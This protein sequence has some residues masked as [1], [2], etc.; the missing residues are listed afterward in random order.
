M[1]INDFP[2]PKAARLAKPLPS[3]SGGGK[4]RS[5]GGWCLLTVVPVVLVLLVLAVPL[6]ALRAVPPWFRSAASR[7]P[8]RSAR[9]G[10]A[11][12]TFT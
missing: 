3:G 9:P 11:A 6:A 2:N 4:R 12:T 7:L 10:A 5:G 1:K 8:A